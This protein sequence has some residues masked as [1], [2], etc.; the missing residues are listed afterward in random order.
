MLKN[1][2]NAI[3]YQREKIIPCCFHTKGLRGYHTVGAITALAS[4]LNRMLPSPLRGKRKER[5]GV[6]EENEG[7]EWLEGRR[8]GKR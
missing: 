8:E 7:G 1:S 4:L 6:S 5:K 3:S 2:W